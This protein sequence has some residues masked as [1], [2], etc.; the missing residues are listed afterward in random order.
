MQTLRR[1]VLVRHG[2]TVG[3]SSIRFYGSTDVELSAEGREQAEAVARDLRRQSFDL[4]V[5]SPLRRSWQSAWIA[6]GGQTV[7]IEPGFREIHF[8]RFEG[9][10]REE[11]QAQD[12]ISYADWQSGAEGF[13]FPHGEARDAF[14][15][16]VAETTQRLLA[17]PA[18]AA[19]LVIHKGVIRR[20]VEQLTGEPVAPDGPA[21][22]ECIVLTRRPDGRWF[23]GSTSSDPVGVDAAAA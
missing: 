13:E 22:G 8:G 3:N 19:L 2:E 5:A 10:T 14:A 23:R 7:R 21:L 9:L 11:I 6:A 18:R 16:R 20:I 12:P 15:A 1:I 4:V 17:S